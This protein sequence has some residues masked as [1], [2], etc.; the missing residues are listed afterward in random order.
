M[1][2]DA[3][4][5]RWLA[6]ARRVLMRRRRTDRAAE[7]AARLAELILYERLRLMSEFARGLTSTRSSEDVAACVARLVPPLLG[8]DAAYLAVE[9][10]EPTDRWTRKYP[11][12]GHDG[13]TLV[14]RREQPEWRR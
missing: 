6:G 8:L 5:H 12:R 13:A 1:K 7:Q 11:L 2:P 9:S 4:G 14:V 10:P 3:E